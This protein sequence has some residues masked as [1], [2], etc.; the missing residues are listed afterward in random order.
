M[1]QLEIFFY[2]YLR[3]LDFRKLR[4]YLVFMLFIQNNTF[5][6]RPKF[7]NFLKMTIITKEIREKFIHITDELMASVFA[8]IFIDPVD[9]VKDGVPNYFTIIKNPQ[10]LSVIRK[11]LEEDKYRFGYEWKRDVELVF[12]NAILFNGEDSL[13]GDF[14]KLLTAQ[15]ARM[16]KRLPVQT[17]GEFMVKVNKYNSI[18]NKLTKT[19]P[20]ITQKLPY[21]VI[22]NPLP[23]KELQKLSI[24]ALS[25]TSRNDVFQMIQILNAFGMNLNVNQTE[26]FV[27]LESVPPLAIATL[28]A[29]VKER[30]QALGLT[31]PK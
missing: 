31:Y 30:Y 18:L 25:L 14:A 13:I 12:S 11:R 26:L 9:P 20:K 19:P 24:A 2:R 1:G 10:C 7:P 17:P 23:S 6:F 16:I 5:T 28:Q 21:G 4:R 29:F 8:S 22:S 3:K 27:N 15:F